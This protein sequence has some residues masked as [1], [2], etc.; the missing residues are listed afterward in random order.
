MGI[1]DNLIKF[2]QDNYKSI[3]TMAPPNVLRILTPAIV[4]A[5][6]GVWQRYKLFNFLYQAPYIKVTQKSLLP[7]IK[8][9]MGGFHQTTFIK[10]NVYNPSAH[11]N[12]IKEQSIILFPSLKIFKFL[13]DNVQ[14]DKYKNKTIH[15]SFDYETIRKL[16]CW[17]IARIR[18]ID[19]KNRKIKKLFWFRNL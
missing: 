17:N 15:F 16:L 10:Y 4:I 7:E 12:L 18:I 1:V 13:E 19:I 6:I 11:N 5:I 9:G 8:D 3:Q 2:A 14:I